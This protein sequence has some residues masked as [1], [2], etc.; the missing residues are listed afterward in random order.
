MNKIVL[1]TALTILFSNA[2]FSQNKDA[3]PNDFPL[4]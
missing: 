2:L 4:K 1:F 3:K